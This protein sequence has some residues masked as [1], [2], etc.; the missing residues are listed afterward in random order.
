MVPFARLYA[1]RRE[2]RSFLA[3]A[4]SEH[5]L[6]SGE[7]LAATISRNRSFYEESNLRAVRDAHGRLREAYHPYPIALSLIVAVLHER[8]DHDLAERVD[9]LM[10][11]LAGSFP[12]TNIR[13]H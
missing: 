4:Y 12:R 8:G 13:H 2:S 11:T 1:K 10:E 7:A 3:P 5:R 9:V 6:E